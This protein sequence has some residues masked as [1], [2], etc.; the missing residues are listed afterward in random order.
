VAGWEYVDVMVDHHSRL[1]HAEVLN[2]LTASC[3]VA[4]LRRAVAWFEL[5]TAY[6]CAR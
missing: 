1:A 3:A 4:F 6:G 5:G 2:D